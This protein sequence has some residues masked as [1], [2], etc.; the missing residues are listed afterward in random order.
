MKPMMRFHVFDQGLKSVGQFNSYTYAEWREDYC[1]TGKLYIKCRDTEYNTGILQ[2]GRYLYRPDIGRAMVIRH[3]ERD[4]ETRTVEVRGFASFDMLSQRVVNPSDT[5]HTMEVYNIEQ[6]I[7][8]IIN[9]NQTAADRAIGAFVTAP[10]KGF[11]DVHDTQFT[12][13]NVL[14]AALTLAGKGEMGLRSAFEHKVPR[15]YF[16]VYKGLDR[17]YKNGV[18]PHIV[19]TDNP[20]NV[21]NLRITDDDADFKNFV[22]VAGEGEGTARVVVPVPNLTNDPNAVIPTGPNR[23]ELWLDRRDLQ[24]GNMT[25]TKYRQ[26]LY[27]KGLE[28]LNNRLNVLSFSCD[29]ITEGS[30]EFRKDYDLGDLVTCESKRYGIR[31]NARVEQ[32]T[33]ITQRNGTILKIQ[34]GKPVLARTREVA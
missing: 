30:H 34:L 4:E 32:V 14:N 1:E 18:N 8:D 2:K 15:Q 22:F 31:F 5:S 27:S 10:P 12:G 19:F 33:E 16:E 17:T 7:Y 26:L 25:V 11:T 29:P 28:E 23:F 9:T 6:G 13:S 20:K 21:N 24:R 3:I